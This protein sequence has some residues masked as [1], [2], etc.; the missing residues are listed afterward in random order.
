MDFPGDLSPETLIQHLGEGLHP[1]SSVAPPL[2]Q[3]SNFSFKTVAEMEASFHQALDGDGYCYSRI[4]NPTVDLAEQKIAALEG[5]ERCRLTSS[6]MSAISAAILAN[7]ESGAHVLCVDSVYAPV[8]SL[9]SDILARFGVNV[10]YADARDTESFLDLVKRETRVIYLESPTSHLF[11]LQDLRSIAAFAKAKGIVTMV[12]N[13]YATPLFQKP[14]ELGVDYVLYSGTKYFGGHSDLSAG[15]I[16]A[17]EARM[18]SILKDEINL[19]G[20]ALAPFPA[21]LVIRG[22][23]TL[24][25]RLR[26]HESSANAVATWLQSRPEVEVVNHISLPSHPQRALFESQM[27]GSTG[28]FSFVPKN[29]DK[30]SHDRFFDSLRLF[31]MAFSWG[32]HESLAVPFVHPASKTRLIRLYCGLEDPR[33]LTRDLEQAMNAWR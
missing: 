4:S 33:D 11:H 24:A 28:L 26:H 14:L 1:F 22:L 30:A 8:R 18:K 19:L 16:C 10:T 3:T 9:F 17:S 13:T 32:G 27:T 31:K 5:A 15:A 2:V 7:V 25:L 20:F 12:D 6:G 21:W 29:Q 23:R